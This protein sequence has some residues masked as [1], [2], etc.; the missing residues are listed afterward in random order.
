MYHIDDPAEMTPEER[1]RE[2]AE[3]LAKGF[4]RWKRRSPHIEAPDSR[5]YRALTEK[6]LDY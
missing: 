6:E 3:I 1:L 4:L 5:E 2:V